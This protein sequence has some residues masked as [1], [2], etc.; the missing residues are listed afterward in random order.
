MD[1]VLDSVFMIRPFNLSW[2]TCEGL[3]DR[4]S[5]RLKLSVI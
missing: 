5:S 4:R 2:L 1:F 3:Q